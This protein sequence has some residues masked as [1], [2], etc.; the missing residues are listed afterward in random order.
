[1]HEFIRGVSSLA[2]FS[3]YARKLFLEP[4]SDWKVRKFG[5]DFRTINSEFPYSANRNGFSP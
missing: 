3:N 1:M 2:H 4:K 5:K